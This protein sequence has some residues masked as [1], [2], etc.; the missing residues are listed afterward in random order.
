MLMLCRHPWQRLKEPTSSGP[1]STCWL[2]WALAKPAAAS[3]CA[4]PLP[5]ALQQWL[6]SSLLAD[7]QH[8]G[9]LV[10]TFDVQGAQVRLMGQRQGAARLC[11][12]SAAQLHTNRQRTW[13]D[14]KTITPDG[15]DLPITR[16]ES[17]TGVAFHAVPSAVDV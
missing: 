8:K 16:P 13:M 12:M 4:P 17:L 9:R 7:P 6:G 5:A 14:C 10:W 3:P 2:L 15:L 11:S 1:L